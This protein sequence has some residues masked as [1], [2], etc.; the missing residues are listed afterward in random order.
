MVARDLALPGRTGV[1]STLVLLPLIH[2]CR[3]LGCVYIF[4]RTDVNSIMP[5]SAWSDLSGGWSS[6]GGAVHQKKASVMS[7]GH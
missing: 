1:A 5:R 7:G 6:G 2:K 4:S 3:A